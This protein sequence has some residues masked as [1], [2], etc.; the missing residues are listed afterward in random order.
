MLFFSLSKGP[1][2]SAKI[3]FNL[4]MIESQKP[5]VMEL[6]GMNAMIADWRKES[7]NLLSDT[8][9]SMAGMV[10]NESAAMAYTKCA[11][12][13]EAVMSSGPFDPSQSRTPKTDKIIN[14]A[15]R[16]APVNLETIQANRTCGRSG[17]ACWYRI[18][19]LQPW[20]AGWFW[21]WLQDCEDTGEQPLNFP[22]GVIED[23]ETRRILSV[24]VTR[25]SFSNEKPQ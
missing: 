19:D 24:Y 18:T 20:R 13:L 10:A 8:L 16:S 3:V 14:D 6:L 25:I 22:V 12:R 1:V 11:D 23:M 17:N 4:D 5:E 2:M 7:R 21:A 9:E 15:M